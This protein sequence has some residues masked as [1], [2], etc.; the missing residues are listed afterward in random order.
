MQATF[1]RGPHQI[2]PKRQVANE[3]HRIFSIKAGMRIVCVESPLEADAIYWAESIPEIVEL[4]EQPLRIQ[5]PIGNKP[6]Y[7]FDLS[8]KY[9]SS[10]ELFFEIKPESSLIRN[11]EGELEPAHWNSIESICKANFYKCKVLTDKDI[12]KKEQEIANWRRLLP[13]A[14]FAYENPHPDLVVV[15]IPPLLIEIKS[16]HFSLC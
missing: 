7:T 1:I 14:R 5:T 6:Y 16:R 11:K 13:Y 9:K 3:F 10:D 12:N 4:C 8:V 2:P 15:V